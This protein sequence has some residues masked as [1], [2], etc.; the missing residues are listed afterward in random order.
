MSVGAPSRFRAENIRNMLRHGLMTLA[1][2]CF[3]AAPCRR[4]APEAAGD[5]A[6]A[7]H[8]VQHAGQ[9]ARADRRRPAAGAA[10]AGPHDRVPALHAG[11]VARTTHPLQAEFDRLRDYLALMAIRM[12]PRLPSTCNCR[13]SSATCRC[14]RCC[15]SRWWRTPSST[16]WSRR[17]RAAGS[18]VRARRDGGQPAARSDRHR[19]RLGGTTHGSGFGLA[20]VRERLA[21]L[22]GIRRG[23]H[24]RTRRHA[25]PAPHP[26]ACLTTA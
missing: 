9:P 10:D 4:G 24:A 8:A 2:C 23:R 17:S 26:P 11:C 18:T 3:G 16:G 25:A 21:T 19:R 7:A 1:F 13:R 5:A 6:R 20:Q 14:R 12:G 15:C 22:H